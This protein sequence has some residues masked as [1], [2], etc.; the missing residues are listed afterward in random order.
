[1]LN[2]YERRRMII[3][4]RCCVLALLVLLPSVIFPKETTMAV[5]DFENNSLFSAESYQSLTKGL[6]DILITELNRVQ[7]VQ[8]VE[9]RKLQAMLDELKLSQSG[10]IAED[11]SLEV[12]RMLGARHLVFG[13]YMVTLKEKI[14]IDVRIV[15]VETGLTIRAEEMT[16]KTHDILRLIKKLSQHILKDLR[17]QLTKAEKKTLDESRKLSM[18]AVVCYSKGVD[19]EDEGR[20]QEAISHYQKALEIEPHFDQ[21]RVRLELLLD[22]E[23][24][25]SQ[26]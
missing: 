19:S 16:G 22:K 26:N 1:M 2:K 18:E 7:S 9:R 5:L 17:V 23:K 15:E 11:R 12:G 21:V 6:A 24:A 10:L 4:K 20:L 13:S 14:R 3:R 25:V 8:V